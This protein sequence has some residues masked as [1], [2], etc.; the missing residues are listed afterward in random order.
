MAIRCGKLKKKNTVYFY[1]VYFYVFVFIK[2]FLSIY[3]FS[4]TVFVVDVSAG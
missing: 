1:I 4:F 3:S 2:V